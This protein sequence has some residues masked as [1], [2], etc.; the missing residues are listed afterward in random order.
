MPKMFTVEKSS[1]AEKSVDCLYFSKSWRRSEYILVRYKDPKTIFPRKLRYYQ[2]D[3]SR[4]DIHSEEKERGFFSS[5]N[6]HKICLLEFNNANKILIQVKAKLYRKL[7]S[8]IFEKS[9]LDDIIIHNFEQEKVKPG[10]SNDIEKRLKISTTC[11]KKE[12]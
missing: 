6:K 2:S 9:K 12:S 3:I 4:I 7:E 1:F 11:G 8:G 5:K 10:R